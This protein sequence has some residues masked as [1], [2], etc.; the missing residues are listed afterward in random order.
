MTAPTCGNIWISEDPTHANC[1][2]T[3]DLTAANRVGKLVTTRAVHTSED[4]L[5]YGMFATQRPFVY[6]PCR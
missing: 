1:V 4:L 6:H 5:L 3:C 2:L